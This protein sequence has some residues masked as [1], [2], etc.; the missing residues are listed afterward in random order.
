MI[1]TTP[2][3][4]GYVECPNFATGNVIKCSLWNLIDLESGLHHFEVALGSSEGDSNVHDIMEISAGSNEFSLAFE[5]LDNYGQ[6]L[7]YFVTVVAF[8]RAMLS[9]RIFSSAIYIDNTPPIC[10]SLVELLDHESFDV[11]EGIRTFPSYAE[12]AICQ[13][14]IT[15]LHIAWNAFIDEETGIDYYEVALGTSQEGTQ[16]VGFTRIDS[17]QSSYIFTN[18]NL[19]HISIAY[20]TVRGYNR[21]GL[22]TTISSNGVFISRLSAGLIPLGPLQVNDGTEETDL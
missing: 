3:T 22:H 18:I 10:N 6:N 4:E 14:D 16:I 17:S 11:S 9:T 19:G 2:P 20:A 12:D 1:D 15:R 21:A 13:R 5:S 7:K 8:N